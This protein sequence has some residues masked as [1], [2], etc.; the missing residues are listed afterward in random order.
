[1]PEKCYSKSASVRIISHMEIPILRYSYMYDLHVVTHSIDLEHINHII[2]LQSPGILVAAIV[3]ID[4][5]ESCVPSFEQ[6]Q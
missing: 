1:M 3:L 4:L 6:F 2:L 5:L